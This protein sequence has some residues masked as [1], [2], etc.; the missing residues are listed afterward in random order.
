MTA[1]GWLPSG[2]R[3]ARHS[4]RG[5]PC[6]DRRP[7]PPGRPGVDPDPHRGAFRRPRCGG[8]RGPGRSAGPDRG[9]GRL[10]PDAVIVRMGPEAD[11]IVRALRA[12]SRPSRWSSATTT[13]HACG[14]TR[15]SAPASPSSRSPRAPCARRWPTWS[16]TGSPVFPEALTALADVRPGGHRPAGPG[17]AGRARPRALTASAAHRQAAPRRADAPGAG[18]SRPTT[19]RPAPSPSTSSRSP[20]PND[21]RRRTGKSPATRAAPGWRSARAPAGST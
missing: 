10:H 17:R 16:I 12:A 20:G 7:R 2:P 1:L 9:R 19:A 4:P 18:T 15:R 14:S 3:P 21:S 13:S 8:R 11:A 5:E 6:P